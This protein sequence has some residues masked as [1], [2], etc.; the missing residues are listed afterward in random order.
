MVNAPFSE[1]I[2]VLCGIRI[3]YIR[4]NNANSACL[5]L[6]KRLPFKFLSYCTLN[7]G[8]FLMEPIKNCLILLLIASIYIKISL[9]SFG[10]ESDTI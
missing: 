6:F 3:G 9:K 2:A 10:R 7:F 5:A 4:P 1:L 8:L